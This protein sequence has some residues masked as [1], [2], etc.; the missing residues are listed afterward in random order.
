VAESAEDVLS[1]YEEAHPDD[2]RP[3]AAIEAARAF[4]NGSPRTRL[5]RVAALDAHRAA[6]DATTEAACHAARAAGDAASAAYLHPLPNATQV[7]HILRAA[8]N[9]ARAAEVRAGND[10]AV[11]EMAI[12]QARERATPLLID[13]LRRYQPAPVGTSRVGQLMKTLDLSLRGT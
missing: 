6:K 7:G 3:R 11:G 9:A 5:Q 2:P 10:P 1:F 12:E 8:A 4:A 13:V